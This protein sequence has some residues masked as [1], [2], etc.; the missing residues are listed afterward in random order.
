MQ[1]KFAFPIKRLFIKSNKAY[2][3][4]IRALIFFCAKSILNINTECIK[5]LLPA[6]EVW[7][8]VMFYTCASF[9]SQGGVY[10]SMQWSVHPW[11]DT[12][13]GRHPMSRHPLGR[14][15]PRQT[16][17]GETHIPPLGRHPTSGQTPPRQIPSS[18]PEMA[19]EAGGTHPTGMHSCYFSDLL[20][21]E[22]E[23]HE[24]GEHRHILLCMKN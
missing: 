2:L 5:F 23:K 11:A 18:T 16:P 20:F 10:H 3:F 24:N 1:L 14:H 13:L 17:P 21:H 15:S 12:P 7:G 19:T 22:R 9:C 6:N 4:R 8:K